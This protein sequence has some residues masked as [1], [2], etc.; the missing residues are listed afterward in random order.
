MEMRIPT[1][2]ECFQNFIIQNWKTFGSSVNKGMQ[3]DVMCSF[4][5]RTEVKLKTEDPKAQYLSDSNSSIPRS[6][7]AGL[8]INNVAL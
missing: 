3:K 8:D 6:P 1:D 5:K 2:K 4:Q 7:L